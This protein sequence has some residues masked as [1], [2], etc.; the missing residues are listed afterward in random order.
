MDPNSQ[1]QLWSRWTTSITVPFHVTHVSDSFFQEMISTTAR[2][3]RQLFGSVTEL[4]IERESL[5]Y[6]N[7][8]T[9][10]IDCRTEGAP[11]PD[12]V[13]RKRQMAEIARFFGKNLHRYG[14]VDIN[15]DVRIEAGDIG[16]GSPRS[17]LILAPSIPFEGESNE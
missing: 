6:L 8:S 15:I 12:L 3:Y 5:P 13:F 9:F 1:N 2:V 4:K 11:A 16:D 7:T 17:Q 10:R 14:Q